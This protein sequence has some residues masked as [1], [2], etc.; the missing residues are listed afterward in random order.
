MFKIKKRI[1]YWTQ[2]FYPYVGGVEVLGSRFIPTLEKR[3]FEFIVVTS[4]G[5]LNLPDEDEHNG[6]K[7][8]RLP[9]QTALREK[10]FED[11]ITS[12]KRLQQIKQ[13]FKPDI[14]HFNFTDP[15]IFFHW[16][17]QAAHPAK[18]IV[19]IRLAVPSAPANEQTLL[20]QTFRNA[21][22]ITTNS[23]AMLADVH[24]AVPETINYSST[25]YNGL[26]APE[27]MPDHITF[28]PLHLLAIG[29]V[30]PEKGFDIALEAMPEILAKRPDARLTIA[31]DGPEKAQLEK[32]VEALGI[33]SAVNFTGWVTPEKVYELINEAS[34]VVVPS[35]WREAFGLVAL[36]AAQMARPVVASN[37]GGL[38]EVIADGQTGFI[39]EKENATELARAVLQ[40]TES[41]EQ[42]ARMGIAGRERAKEMFNWDKHIDEYE[43]LYQ[44]LL[45][46]A[47][48]D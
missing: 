43:Q 6:I 22:W 16:Q 9:F 44:R 7:I 13:T 33:Q 30:V 37:V 48:V 42:S 8:F 40:L 32:Q 31:G 36:Q 10:N 5:S 23:R 25:I 34:M 21:D 24:Q 1:L 39:I 20:G 18:T 27:M 29:R 35:R 15:S 2:L 45:R 28:Q 47:E 46:S 11:M 4:H 26:E 12:R 17:T 3:G 14:V 41:P 19:S 38:P